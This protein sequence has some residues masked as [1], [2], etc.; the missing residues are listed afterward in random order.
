LA[1]RGGLRFRSRLQRPF[2]VANPLQPTLAPLQFRRQLVAALIG[3]VLRV[4][5]RIGRLRLGEQLRDFLAQLRLL[6]S[7]IRP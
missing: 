7:R 3:T 2:G 5:R 6:L 1:R 4:L